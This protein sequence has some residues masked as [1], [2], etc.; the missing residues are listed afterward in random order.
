MQIDGSDLSRRL[1]RRLSRFERSASRLPELLVLLGSVLLMAG[2]SAFHEPWFDEAQAWMIARSASLRDILLVIPHYEGHTPLWHL[3]LLPVARSGIPYEW[4]LK[5]VVILLAAAATGLILYRAPLPRLMRLVM[6]FT[7]FLFYQYGVVS[8]NY[9]LMLPAFVLAAIFYKTRHTRPVRLVLC[10]AFL[11]AASSYGIAISCGVALAWLIEIWADLPGRRLTVRCLRDRRLLSLAALLV[12]TAGLVWLIRPYS[13]TMAATMP[14]QNSFL[15]RL[16]YMLL[17]APIDAT[18]YQ[19]GQSYSL[20]SNLQPAP[21]GLITALVLG[22]FFNLLLA[23]VAYK[24][25]KLAV[26]SLMHLSLSLFS[27]W[28]YFKPHHLGIVTLA[29]LF[30][31]WI[32]S[33]QPADQKRP[34]PDFILKISDQGRELGKLRGLL[35]VLVGACLAVSV[36]WTISASIRDIRYPYGYGRET[37]A[38][39]AQAQLDD[40]Q[41]MAMWNREWLPASETTIIDTNMVAGVDILPYF[42]RNLIFNLNRGSDQYP[43]LIHQRVDNEENYLAWRERGVPDLLL[44][45]PDLASVYGDQVSIL[46]Y[47]AVKKITS[48]FIWKD[49]YEENWFYLFLRRDLLSHY[50]EIEEIPLELAFSGLSEP[51]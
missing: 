46:D 39:I 9:S 45:L 51:R 17:I 36:Y 31:V 7:F 48:S 19:S 50:P 13:D 1:A 6:P 22:L 30:L 34:T 38:F 35:P 23:Y 29:I 32:C 25:K 47:A 4:G 18:L 16:A 49:G 21:A 24:S 44:G 14:P 27:A 12:Y 40:L 2:V 20:L 15:F 5:S 43:Y 8:R 33:E 10:L 41:I 3:V 26:W 37:A 28:V 42:T 11:A